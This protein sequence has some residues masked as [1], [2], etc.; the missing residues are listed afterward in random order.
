MARASRPGVSAVPRQDDAGH[1]QV[2]RGGRERRP[3]SLRGFPAGP[4]HRQRGTPRG[5]PWCPTGQGV[6]GQP[7]D[8]RRGGRRHGPRPGRRPWPAPSGT[9]ATSKRA[10]TPGASPAPGVVG[11]TRLGRDQ[12][13]LRAMTNPRVPAEEHLAIDTRRN[14]N[15]GGDVTPY[16]RTPRPWGATGRGRSRLRRKRPRGPPSRGRSSRV[17]L[18]R[19]F[20]RPQAFHRLGRRRLDACSRRHGHDRAALAGVTRDAIFYLTGPQPRSRLLLASEVVAG[21][22]RWGQLAPR[23]IANPVS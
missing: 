15:S 22:E 6:Q 23:A 13:G 12:P 14:A 4:A 8:R 10:T 16:R 19:A 18:A 7:P 17:A 9:A 1:S 20:A 21:I 2:L 3:H 5:C 11:R